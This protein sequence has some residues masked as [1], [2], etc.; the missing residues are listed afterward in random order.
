[1]KKL[2]TFAMTAAFAAALSLGGPAEAGKK[3]EASCVKGH[4]CKIGD[5]RPKTFQRH[6]VDGVAVWRHKSYVNVSFASKTSKPTRYE[7]AICGAKKVEQVL[8]E[9]AGTYKDVK[10][11]AP[12][13]KLKGCD[14]YVLKT[15]GQYDGF[16][17]T[18]KG[19]TFKV[20]VQKDGKPSGFSVY[21]A[22]RVL[23][24]RDGHY[25]F[26]VK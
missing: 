23:P 21:A 5:E 25:H 11:R 8:F 19:K 14:N 7:V 10:V 17:V 22:G 26:K 20:F 24:A 2:A 15:G 6:K 12:K 1:M 9:K 18:P 13:G 16:R 4:L 3:N